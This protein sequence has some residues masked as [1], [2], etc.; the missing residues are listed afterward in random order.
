MG[1]WSGRLGWAD[2]VCGA[3][4]VEWNETLKT[5]SW[6]YIDIDGT[7]TN[8]PKNKWAEPRQPVIDLVKK[9]ITAGD[10]VVVWSARGSLYAE[11]FTRKHGIAAV[12]CLGKPGWLIDDNPEVRPAGRLE[13][14][15]PDQFLEL[16]AEPDPKKTNRKGK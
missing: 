1:G 10:Q 15:S 2:F 7:L 5:M 16:F 9:R 13:V 12:A 6:L 8:S 3:P 14:L 4:N 11:Q